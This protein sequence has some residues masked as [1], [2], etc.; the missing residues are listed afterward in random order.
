L[1]TQAC[2]GDS[3]A[4][5]VMSS[6]HL[7]GDYNYAWPTA[8]VAVM[9]R[10]FWRFDDNA[11]VLA[12]LQGQTPEELAKHTENYEAAFATPIAAAQ[13]GFIDGIIEPK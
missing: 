6:K 13:R 2:G 1:N 7:R 4:Y 11:S 10:L 5:D 8:E 9:G 12:S 3:G